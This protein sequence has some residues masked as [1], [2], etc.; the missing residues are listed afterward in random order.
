MNTVTQEFGKIVIEL[1]VITPVSRPYLLEKV[2]HSLLPLHLYFKVKWI[3]ALDDILVNE[4]EICVQ[5]DL[6]ISGKHSKCGQ[7]QR[8]EAIKH[9]TDGWVYYLDDDNGI[10]PDFPYYAHYYITNFPSHAVFVFDQVFFDGTQRLRTN[11]IAIDEVDTASCLFHS[12]VAKDGV[13]APYPG[14]K[15]C[16]DAKYILDVWEQHSTKFLFT[17]VTASYWNLFR[18]D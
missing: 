10:H 15:R 18:P 8:N 1:N 6:I 3:L 7:Y 17:G 11:R 4:S 5:A 14:R 12:S 16:C 13:W 9:V 2:R